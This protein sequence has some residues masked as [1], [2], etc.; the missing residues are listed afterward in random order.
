MYVW[1]KE[2][3]PK[4]TPGCIQSTV[5]LPSRTYK[6][7]AKQVVSLILVAGTQSITESLQSHEALLTNYTAWSTL[8]SLVLCLGD[9]LCCFIRSAKLCFQERPLRHVRRS[10]TPCSTGEM[11]IAGA[12]ETYLI[13]KLDQVIEAYDILPS[14]V[15]LSLN[16]KKTHYLKTSQNLLKPFCAE[17]SVE[18][19]LRGMYMLSLHCVKLVKPLRRRLRVQKT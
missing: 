3:V 14:D 1:R 18:I 5:Y 4:I 19:H 15:G 8:S 13:G 12:D 6:A 11:L 17:N 10:P 9:F 7:K 16:A 2:Y